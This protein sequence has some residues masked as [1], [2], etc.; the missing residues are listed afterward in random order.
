MG[1]A[2]LLPGDPRQ[3]GDYWLAGRLGAGGQ[4]VVYEGYAPGGA[5]VAVKALHG[6]AVTDKARARF[7]REVEAARR[8][9][10][11]CTARILAA[12]VDAEPP[13]LVSEYVAGPDLQHAVTAGGPF[14]PD[15]LHRLATGVATAL[16]AIHHA[17]VVH[18][19]LKPGNVLLGPDGPRVIDFG[20]ARTAEMTRSAGGVKGTPRYM[21]PE[22]FRGGEP[23]AEQDVWAWGAV[24]LFAALGRPPF[25]GD[26]LP[27]VMNSVLHDEPDVDAL[28]ASLR[29]VVE[30]AL[31]K[32]PADRP[33]SRDVL[34]ALVG[35]GGETDRL[36]AE[37]SRAATGIRR[38]EQAEPDPS[39]GEVAEEV[40]SRL[41]AAAQEAVPSILLRLV[42][43][44]DG[45]ED[46]LRRARVD[47]LSTD[48][49]APD[50]VREVLDAFTEAGLMVRDGDRV[51]LAGAALL[52]AWPRLRAWVEAE[53]DGLTTHLTL[54]NAA[55]LWEE[56]GRKKS[57]LY[58]GTPLDRAMDWAATG[59]RHLAL[60]RTE[61]AF[62]AAGVAL[63]R[64]RARLR[65]VL[66]AALA[67]LLAVSVAM[68][69][70]TFIQRQE[71]LAQRDQA[72]AA[73]LADQSAALRRL[74]PRTGRRLAIA[75]GRL[76]TKAS[77]QEAVVA[78]LNQWQADVF[79]PPGAD[80]ERGI[81]YLTADGRTL[82]AKTDGH[83]QAWDVE[84]RRRIRDFRFPQANGNHSLA[85]SPD[86]GRAVRAVQEGE[87]LRMQLWDTATGRDLGRP[88]GEDVG[89]FRFSPSGNLLMAYGDV[90]IEEGEAKSGLGSDGRIELWNVRTG[91]R[92]LSRDEAPLSWAVSP[93][94]RYAALAWPDD[95]LELL[96]LATGKRVATPWLDQVLDG[97]RVRQVEFG[98]KGL[99][100]ALLV[101]NRGTLVDLS[102][103]PVTVSAV[104][105]VPRS[106]PGRPVFSPDGRLLAVGLRVWVLDGRSSPVLSYD[107]RAGW[108]QECRFGPDSQ[109]LRCVNNRRSVHTVDIRDHVHRTRFAETLKH[110]DAV[111]DRGAG[112]AAVRDNDEIWMW[113]VRRGHRAG[114]PVIRTEPFLTSSD[115]PMALGAGGRLLATTGDSPSPRVDIWDTA[116]GRKLVSLPTGD[117]VTALVFAPDGKS[118]ATLSTGAPQGR[119]T[120]RF[121]QVSGGRLLRTITTYRGLGGVAFRPDGRAVAVTPGTG[122]VEFPSGRILA[123]GD[124]RLTAAALAA[125]GVTAA[126]VDR[127]NDRDV[128][129]HDLR[130]GR[131]SATVMLKSSLDAA[132]FSP[133]G[134][135]LA[136]GERDGSVRLW[137]ARSGR[138][139]ALDLPAHPSDGVYD[140]A[141]SPDGQT[142]YS[143][144]KD[145]VI[146]AHPVGVTGAVA[147]LC[148]RAGPPTPGEWARHIPEIPYRGT[149]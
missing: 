97:D 98:P 144:G 125:D 141:F 6:E 53:R 60:N 83:V 69:V 145:G 21:A 81:G 18:R 113:D 104:A 10:S 30:A 64:S 7:A 4:G 74:D 120:L 45:A 61:Q 72:V 148:R 56:H 63:R 29:A 43:P 39:L 77:V 14:A 99:V 46:T 76:S 121:W 9:A 13:Y 138:Q 70:L 2:P 137:D 42:T 24:V 52:R 36:L 32:D 130:T 124:P 129:I 123:S 49:A 149:C 73:R 100:L 1:F 93:D 119:G 35:G 31:S 55:R 51:T 105:D 57:D 131:R 71:A 116:S 94:D 111:V 82:W 5:R 8:V 108:Y 75:A 26:S 11:F 40:Y 59:R 68:T 44:G 89:F 67:G 109:T 16:T 122:L 22:V 54:S 50:A 126:S 48:R 66:T 96:D 112:V 78:A 106:W 134:R 135:L 143:V 92:V 33:S 140:L 80:R 84:T 87:K 91:E 128:I 25:S 3:L 20:I 65:R 107:F 110:D 15:E 88:F 103:A 95:G 62:L 27:A 133:D 102:T 115:T 47:E 58:Q 34:L 86:G 146:H 136:T 90:Y 147:E 38:T 132:A 19:D 28:P 85:I 101:K 37:G 17:G 23:T 142:L 117:D 79:D 139:F 118:L 114:T 41:G 127:W 12:D